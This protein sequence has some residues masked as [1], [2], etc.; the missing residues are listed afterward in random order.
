MASSADL[1]RLALALTGTTEAPH[2]NR[3]AFKVARIYATV[4]ADGLTAN[5]KLEPAEQEFRCLVNP[6]AFTPVPNAWGKQGW[7]TVTLTELKPDELAG[8]LEAAWRGAQKS[9]QRRRA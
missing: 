1:R 2:F 8:V 4:P 3:T 9:P 5:L 7:T 6:Q